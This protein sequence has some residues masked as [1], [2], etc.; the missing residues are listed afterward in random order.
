M[1]LTALGFS[2]TESEIRLRCGHS[3]LGMRL[4]QIVAGLADLP[5]SVEYPIDWG[6]DDLAEAT[7]QSVFPI[8][9]IDL[10]HIEGLFAFHSV[11][12]SK[13]T[14]EHLVVHDPLYPNSA[15]H[16]GLQT[17]LEAWEGAD[18]ECLTIKL[19]QKV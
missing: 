11:V 7:R 15:R 14:S 5:L 4:N 3:N 17:F 19:K 18:K 1:V 10:R 12:V 8:V 9:G 2:L 16:I 6:L 13:V